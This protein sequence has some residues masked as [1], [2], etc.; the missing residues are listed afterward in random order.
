MRRMFT[1]LVVAATT[2]F[3]PISAR[4]DN[5]EIADQIAVNL[6]ENGKLSQYRIAVKFDRGAA[7]LIGCVRNREQMRS[8]LKTAL[9][10]PE[11]KR[12]VN[13]LTIAPPKA[14]RPAAGH[15]SALR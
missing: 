3:A 6:Q 5:Q 7:S 8:A 14:A 12:V 9:K 15:R 2:V 1:G 10:S 11:V 13:G 4:A